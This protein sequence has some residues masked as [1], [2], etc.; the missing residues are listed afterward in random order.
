MDSFSLSLSLRVT[1]F[2]LEASAM[3]PLSKVAAVSLPISN[4]GFPRIARQP[5]ILWPIRKTE[6]NGKTWRANSLRFGLKV[7][8][9]QT[10]LPS[11]SL[12]YLRHFCIFYHHF[13][14]N[15]DS[16][17]FFFFFFLYQLLNRSLNPMRLFCIEMLIVSLFP[18]PIDRLEFV[19]FE[20]SSKSDDPIYRKE[21]LF[22]S[23]LIKP[24]VLRDFSHRP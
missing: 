15:L 24:S 17:F 22:L 2:V 21:I 18:S 12:R 11:S 8:S 3:L 23:S 19:E 9:R 13:N 7:E 5:R 6:G 20:T 14:R 10:F 16:N 1:S 4:Y